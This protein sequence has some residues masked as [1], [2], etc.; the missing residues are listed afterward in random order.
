MFSSNTAP[1]TALTVKLVPSTQIDPFCAM[2]L[3]KA[4]G[5]RMAKRHERAS[6]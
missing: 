3:A 2:Y 1:L 4:S 6:S 5:A